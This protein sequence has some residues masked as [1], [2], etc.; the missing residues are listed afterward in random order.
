MCRLAVAS[1]SNPAEETVCDCLQSVT[2]DMRV[3]SVT[4]LRLA[5][6]GHGLSLSMDWA[7]SCEHTPA[8]GPRFLLSP[9]RPDQ[10]K[11]ETYS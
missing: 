2:L 6:L 9:K 7:P 8:P 5:L 4:S 3:K 10:Q 1:C 11:E